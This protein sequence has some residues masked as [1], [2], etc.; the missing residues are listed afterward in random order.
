MKDKTIEAAEEM[1][2]ALAVMDDVHPDVDPDQYPLR[3]M[4]QTTWRR[5]QKVCKFLCHHS[6]FSKLILANLELQRNPSPGK[7]CP[8]VFYER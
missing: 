4:F 6:H 7:F 8:V 1:I 2:Y 3:Y 5:F